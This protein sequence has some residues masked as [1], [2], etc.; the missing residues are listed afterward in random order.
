MSGT[1]QPAQTGSLTVASGAFG[2]FPV[3]YGY[4]PAEGSRCVTAQ[5]NWTSQAAYAEDLSGL[6]AM[7]VE[8]TIQSAFVDNSTVA[9]PVT[10]TIGGT[11]QVV[12]IPPF[13]QAI[14]PLF[15]VGTP[16]FA[17]SVAATAAA[18]TRVYLLNVPIGGSSWGTTINGGVPALA[19]GVPAAGA[20]GALD[21]AAVVTQGTPT[22]YPV[23]TVQPLVI[24]PAGNLRVALVSNNGQE[25][26]IG[27]G[28]NNLANAL[29]MTGI[30]YYTAPTELVNAQVSGIVADAFGAMTVNTEA[31]APTYSAGFWFGTAANGTDIFTING[32]GGKVI[33]IHEI[34][35][36]NN[37]GCI[38]GIIKRS[39]L[40]SGGTSSLVPIIP[41]DRNS[42]AATAVVNAYTAV[43]TGLG[44][45]VG[46][47][48][49][50]Q[51]APTA[52]QAVF[53][54]GQTDQSL[55]LRTATET[56][57]VNIAIASSTI[58][59]AGWG[60]KVKWSEV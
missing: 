38:V 48:D 29:L 15:F 3:S 60:I 45:Q 44:A 25:P 18:V 16:S 50:V 22:A 23:G 56:V 49:I 5:Y 24:D 33:R 39:G 41:H 46:V 55:V 7:G 40:D 54:Y 19:Q 4:Y 28:V 21:M 26:V 17:I 30:T 13:A 59:A 11:G 8:T 37:V 58:A 57:A 31:N 51:V 36:L 47:V 12:V 10:M 2:V 20:S 43:P 6:A 27:S 34:T 52:A 9:Q 42:P 53:S 1:I 35:V 14:V 32:T